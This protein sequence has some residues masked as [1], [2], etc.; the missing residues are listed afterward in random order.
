[1]CCDDAYLVTP[2]VF[3]LARNG[4]NNGCSYKTLLACNPRDYD[5]KGGAIALSRWIE[6]M[7]SVQARG[8]E[9]AVGMTWEEFKALLVEAFC[10]NVGH[11][12]KVVRRGK[13]VE[14]TNKQRGL[15]NDNKRA[16]LGKGYVAADPPRDGYVEPYPKSDALQDP[17]VITGTLFLNDHFATVLLDSRADFRFI[18]TKFVSLLNVK[19]SIVKPGYVIE[20]ADD[21]IPLGYGS[22]D[23]IVGMDWLSEHKAVI[24]CHEKVVRIPL[25][26]DEMLRVQREH[27]LKFLTPLKSTKLKEQKL[28]DIPVL[29]VHEEDI[30]KTTLRT[31]Y[32]HFKFTVMPFGLTNAPAVFM[33]LMNRV[34]KPYLDKFVIVFIDDILIYSKPKEDHEVYLRLVLKLLKKERL[35]AKFSRYQFWL[36]EVHFLGYVVNRNGI[37]VDL[38]IE[39]VKNGK[40]PKTPSE[41]RSF[42][43][44]ASYYRRFIVNFSKIV[45]PLTSLT[46]KNQKIWMCAHE[47]GKKALGTRLDM[48]TGYHPQIDGQKMVQETTDKLALIKERLEAARDR[49]KSYADKRLIE[50]GDSYKAPPEEIGE[51]VRAEKSTELGSNDT[52][53]MCGNNIHKTTKRDYNWRCPAIRSPIIRAKDKGKQKVVESEVPKKRKF[54]EQIDAQVARE[55]EEEFA[56]E[57][58]RSNEVIVKHLQEYEQAEA[59]LTVGER[60]ELI[61]ELVKYQDHHV[62]ILKYQAQQ[63]KPL[64][65]KEQREFYMSVFRSHARWKTKHFRGMKLEEI[66]EKFIPVW[67]QLEDFVPMSSKEEGKRVK[68]KGLKLDQGSAKRMKTSEDVSKEDLKGMMQLVPLEEVYV[69]ALQVKHPIIDWEIHSEEKREYWKIIGLGGHTAVYQFFIDMLKQFDKEDL[70]Q[71]W[72]LVKE[73]LSIRPATKDKE[74]ELWVELKRLFEPDF[75]DQLWTHNQALMH[76]SVEWK[77]Y[78]TCGVHH[79][80][81]KDQVVFMLVEKDYPLRKGLANM[82]ICNKLQVSDPTKVK[83]RE[84]EHAERE[85]RL[86]DSTVRCVVS[87]LQVAF[88]RVESELEASVKRL[89]DEGGSA[90]HGDSVTGGGQETGTEIVAGVRIVAEENLAAEKPKRPRK[91][92]Q[93]ATDAGELLSSSILNIEYD[94]E[95]VATF[96]FVTS[97]VS[98]TLEHESG[99]P[100]D[101]I[102]GPNLYLSPVVSPMMIEV[103]ITTHVA[104]IPYVPALEPSMKVITPVH[105]SMFH[106]SDST[107]TMRPD[108]AGS[109]HVSGKELSMGLRRLILKTDYEE[110]FTEFSVGTARQ[111]CLSA[112]VRMRTEY[113]LSERRRLEYEFEKQDGLLKAKDDEVEGLKARLLLKEAEAAKAIHLRGKVSKFEVIEKSLQDETNTLKERNA[114]LEKE[115]NALDAKLLAQG[116]ELAIVKCLNS[117]EYLS[118]LKEAISKGIEKGMQDGLFD[119]ITHGKEDASV[120]TVMDAIR[121]EEPLNEKL[122][123]NELQP[124]I[125]QLMVHIH[126]S[127]NKVVIGAS[128]LTLALDVSSTKSTSDIVS[129]SANTTIAHLTT[130]ASASTVPPITIVD[131]EVMGTDGPKDAQRSD[132]EFLEFENVPCSRKDV[133][134]AVS[135]FVCSF[136]QYFHDFIWSIPLRSELASILRMACIVSSVDEVGMPIST[137]ITAFVAYVSKNGVSPLL[138]LIIVRALIPSP[139]L[140]FTLPTRSPVTVATGCASIHLVKFTIRNLTLPGPSGKGPAMSIPHFQNGHGDMMGVKFYCGFLGTG[141]WEKLVDAILLSRSAF[142]FSSLGTCL[143]EISLKV[144]ARPAIKASYYASLLIASNLNLRAYVNSIPFGFVIIRSTTEPS[145]HD[146][147]VLKN[148]NDFLADLDRNLLRLASFPFSFC[149]SFKHFGDGK[150]RTA[151]TLSEHTFN[152][153]GFTFHP[154]NVPSLIP[155]VGQPNV[156]MNFLHDVGVHQL[157]HFFI[158]C[159]ISFSTP[160]VSTR[161]QANM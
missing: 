18:S 67:K 55:M 74:K 160:V 14:E 3:A 98:A 114:L 141:R 144:L 54:Q 136:T 153:S 50:F 151:S 86:L 161:F 97:F 21:L 39:A 132:Q 104:S 56:R 115:H 100:A 45:K 150:L 130:L 27:A 25:A 125:D 145:M 17:K 118:A 148:G 59:E 117:P 20:V 48:S 61:N 69:K 84:Q 34:C 139:K 116:M 1:M 53:E 134:V 9:V 12:R 123:L 140:L 4:G 154:R 137:G 95:I 102:T 57:N 63:S 46:Q 85:A 29:R 82:M 16:K 24:I 110:L 60:I 120:E 126:H 103:V 89:F 37:H 156:I 135:K 83:V 65:K 10:P 124:T 75:K 142:L 119:G 22:F 99:V 42:L 64:S 62:K 70:H 146:D 138:D 113:C 105:A 91:K 88:T 7:E 122:G 26:T 36:Q 5:R 81:S 149:M 133:P 72:T 129:A 15:G 121:L 107:G 127:P 31:R 30:P 147:P 106:D 157:F 51:E 112:E 108:A 76:D 13:E 101:S 90:D 94:V 128:A 68:R 40:A 80:F 71:L 111:A 92:R 152:P 66:K 87:L 49:Q 23:V 19:T 93:V 159:F 32:G 78:D 8:R 33:D 52:E 155:K 41:I 96:P 158:D 2:R 35:F 109:S 43:G 6:K 28:E 77:L 47:R 38:S 143:M 58:K 79:V 11:C 44:L 131:Y 73:T